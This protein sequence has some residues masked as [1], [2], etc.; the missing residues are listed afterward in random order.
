MDSVSEILEGWQKDGIE[1]VRFELPDMHGTS[2]SKTIPLRHATDYAERGVNMYGGASVLDL[3]KA[4]MT[5]AIL[6]ASGRVPT[7]TAIRCFIKQY[8]L[9]ERSRIRC[10]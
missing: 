10:N 4:R 9:N 3:A 8:S 1:W 6:M 2:R 7:M 5:G